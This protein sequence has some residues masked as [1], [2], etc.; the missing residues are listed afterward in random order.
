MA[1]NN[2]QNNKEADWKATE[3][4]I[5]LYNKYFS[6]T[7][8]KNLLHIAFWAVFCFLQVLEVSLQYSF[9]LLP[10]SIFAFR[11]TLYG[12]FPFYLL[13][14]FFIPKILLKKKYILF[15]LACLFLFEIS[16]IINYLLAVYINQYVNLQS[17]FVLSYVKSISGHPFFY[18]HSLQNVMEMFWA[19]IY[20][21]SVPV[22]LKLSFDFMVS[23]NKKAQLEKE[24]LL[25]ELN[26]L[27]SQLNPHFLFNALNN[28]YSLSY[29][30]DD[31]ASGMVLQL[32]DL[33][34]YTLYE[35]NAKQVPLEKEI[36]FVKNYVEL[37]RVRYNK[38]T[39]IELYTEYNEDEMKDITI[40]PLIFFNFIENAFKHG[41]NSTIDNAWVKI[42]IAF[43]NKTLLLKIENSY[44][45]VR[46]IENSTKQAA[47]GIGIEN[48]RKRLELLYPG[49]HSLEIDKTKL[50]YKILL[51]INLT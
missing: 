43:K 12:I 9:S 15:L 5:Y 17:P 37:E 33:M 2:N 8:A 19:T 28:I 51:S 22:L 39:G 50:T 16:R 13:I 20:F 21:S 38:Q 27:K 35:T 45:E 4:I 31:R 6:T 3:T 32:A 44:N 40:A 47:G 7:G 34:R 29:K 48:T 14:Y 18:I 36:L 23:V 24:N 10:A 49:K 25:L 46:R 42:H 11:N 30:K 1:N 41:L 26:F